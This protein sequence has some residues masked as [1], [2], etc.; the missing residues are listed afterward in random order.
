MKKITMTRWDR[1]I[2]F[3]RDAWFPVLLGL[4]AILCESTQRMGGDNTRAWLLHLINL[5]HTQRETANLYE[6]NIFL[7]KTGHFLGYGLLGVICA[8]AWTG[9]INRIVR[10]TLTQARLRGAALGVLSVLLIACADEF[11]QSFVPGRT[12]TIHDVV[13]DTTGALLLNALFFFALLRERRQWVRNL[14]DLR[15]QRF[16]MPRL[17]KRRIELAA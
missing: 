8:R 6:F 12:A 4:G 1:S 13:L 2:D 7:R 17:A 16:R 5:V 14:L 3:R 9:Q 15:A 10:F 11:H